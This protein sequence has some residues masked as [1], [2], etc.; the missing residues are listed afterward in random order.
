MPAP[1]HILFRK[2]INQP[3]HVEALFTHF[4]EN[5]MRRLTFLV[6]LVLLPALLLAQGLKITGNVTSTKGEQ[7]VGAGVYIQSMGVGSVTGPDGVYSFT[8]RQADVRGQQVEL[9]A[10]IIGHKK[11]TVKITLTGDEIRQN[12]ELEEDVFQTEAVVVTGIASKTAKAI[13]E[14]SVARIPVADL[15]SVQNFQGLSQLITGK[16]PGVTVNI[17]SG[18][19]GSGWNFFVR[20]G[21]GLN[22]NGQPLIFV[23]GVRLENNSLNF[24]GVGGQAL[25]SLSTLN[26]NDIDNIEV[27]KGPAAASTYGTN[28][29][30]GVVLITTKSGKFAPGAGGKAYSIDY[31]FNFGENTQRFKY[32]SD[33]LNADTINGVLENPGMI[34]EHTLSITGGT[35]S[36][37]YYASYQNRF[38]AGVIPAQNYMDRNSIKA[39]VSSVASDNFSLRFNASYT[40]SKIRQPNNDNNIYGWLLNALAYYPAYVTTPKVAIEAIR[41]M[42]SFNEFI[43]SANL[44]WSPVSNLEITGSGGVEFS[45]YGQDLLYPYGF[46]Y[47]QTIGT[48]NNYNRISRQQTYDANAKYSYRD[49]LVDGLTVVPT[50]GTQ[51]VTRVTRTNN[52]SVQ[53]FNLVSVYDIGSASTV[54][55]RG[56]SQTERREAGIYASLPFNYDNTLFWTL[57]ARRDY[58]SALGSNSPSISYPSASVGLRLDR[59]VTL[60]SEIGMLKLRGAYGESGQLPNT[61]DGLPLT[62]AIAAGAAGNGLVFNALGNMAIEPERIKEFEF[63][64]DAEFLNMFSLEFTYFTSTANKS[65]VRSAYPASTGLGAY[66]FPYNVGS[67]ESHGFESMLQFTPIRELDYELSTSLI[68]NYQANEVKDLGGTTTRLLYGTAIAH[69]VAPGLPKFQFYDYLVLGP[70]FDAAG[71]YIGVTNST[72]QQDLGSN[73]VPTHTGSLTLNFRFMKDFQLYAM[74]EWALGHSAF[75]YTIRRSIAAYSYVPALELQAKLGLLTASRLPEVTRLTPGTPEYIDAANRYAKM[76][77]SGTAYSNFIYKA[78]ILSIRE[79]SLSY[80]ATDLMKSVLPM[81][82]VSGLQVGFSVRNAFKWTKFPL[83]PEVNTAGGDLGS[84]SEEFATLPQ[85]RTFNTWIRFTF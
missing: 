15:T 55:G 22:G 58:A 8:L 46:K 77:P 48:R 1:W 73:S 80:N 52:I 47:N 49:F 18:N 5:H 76:D 53:G 72:A 54:N 75:S 50:V 66:T 81:Q 82:Y 30:N 31:Q 85:P 74:A 33:F 83:D 63:G 16:I 70:K 68:W 34:R 6:F 29:S 60:P 2:F 61:T 24:Y 26:P 4:R 57:G 65:I 21:G 45:D 20:G 79:I 9:T 43:G 3:L 7:I 38:D 28:A 71:K 59:V 12:F 19:A 40:W 13:A 44:T 17:A 37:R 56:D 14:V 35:P 10:S 67:I 84:S 78:D 32:P 36:L 42:H 39:T 23:D 64:F 27:L 62:Y 69:A 11:K 51:I 25:S 41:N